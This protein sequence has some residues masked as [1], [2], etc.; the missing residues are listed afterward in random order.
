[1]YEQFDTIN[2]VHPWREVSPE[3]YVD[4][5]VVFRKGGRVLYFNFLLAKELGLIRKNHP[6]KMRPKLEEAILKTFSIEILNEHDWANRETFPKDGYENRLYMATRYLQTQHKNKQGQT[7]GD[8]RGIWNGVIKKGRKIYDISSRGTGATILSPGAQETDKPV[9]TG[10]EKLGYASGRADLDEMLASAVN[11]EIFYRQ[12]FPT[13]RCLVVIDFKDNTAIGVRAFSNLIRPAHLFRYLKMD[14]YA[15]LKKSFDYFINREVKNGV[16]TLPRSRK[17]RY[18][19]VLELLTLQY[20]KFVALL[21]EEYIFNWFAWDGDNMLAS[22]AMLDYGSIRQFAAKNNKYRYEDVDRFSTCLTEQRREA[23]YLVQTFVQ[24]VYFILKKKKKNLEDFDKDSHLALFDECFERE[25]KRRM[26]WRIGFVN[27]QID[28]LM[29]N[30]FEKVEAF[31][32]VLN[33]FEHVKT[34][35]G[36]EPVPDGIDHPPVFLIRHILWEL[37]AFLLRHRTEAEGEWPLMPE[38]MFCKVMAASY[39]EAK[40]LE[41]TQTRKERAF[42]FQQLYQDLMAAVSRKR[43]V[44]LEEVAKRSEVINH[45]YRN[46]GDGLTWIINESIKQK[47][48][49]DRAQFQEAMERFIESQVLIPQE[50]KPIREEETKS[51]STKAS[52]LRMMQEHLE[53]YRETI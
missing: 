43:W 26:L 13:E 39:A 31:Q 18:L 36:E 52:L 9:R 20:A 40:D 25:R 53:V 24:M 38:D 37:P 35:K 12:G 14:M 46:T 27:G 10:D 21:E 11:S 28:E 45:K 30:H 48:T 17:Q 23:K 32:K 49:F 47:D 34:L 15:E 51:H 6:H 44:T 5:P 50:W 33:Y 2:G 16:W 29:N 8:G 4:Y 3:G 1:M 7:S 41:M 22:G 42:L 19:K